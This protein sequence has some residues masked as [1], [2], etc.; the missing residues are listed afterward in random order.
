MPGPSPP[1]RVRL[2]YF[3][4]RPTYT[5]IPGGAVAVTVFLRETFDPRDGSPLL[6]PGTDGLIHGGVLVEASSPPPACPARVKATSNIAGNP[7]FDFAIIPQLLESKSTHAAG[8]LELS[9]S[10]VFGEV[11]SRTATC[12]T[13][14]LPLG[15][16][17][18]TA[19]GV[20]GEVTFI[21]AMISEN[22]AEYPGD[23]N[24]TNSGFTL[25]PLIRPGRAMITVS[26]K[27]AGPHFAGDMSGLAD[28]LGA[29]S[30]GNGK[31]KT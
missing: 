8:I 16:F 12:E 1:A 7:A 3:F 14:L 2:E 27:V 24:V 22:C 6:A 10:P 21:T 13:V 11:A 5:V 26:P 31:R 29:L 18:F 9:G 23:N 15:T 19:G 25:D 20:P 28:V 4:D 30:K 17:L